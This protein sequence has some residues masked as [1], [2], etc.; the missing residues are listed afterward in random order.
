MFLIIGVTNFLFILI[1]GAT[2]D[3]YSTTT[4]IA[5]VISTIIG[6]IA[7]I[8]ICD[9]VFKKWSAWPIFIFLI[10]MAS[11]LLFSVLI[12]GEDDWWQ[13]MLASIQAILAPYLTYR[14]AIQ[15]K[16]F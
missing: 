4:A 5:S 1:M 3:P 9:L 11:F 10:V 16:G 6:V 15:R 8:K 7:A 13:F 12:F 2:D 14:G